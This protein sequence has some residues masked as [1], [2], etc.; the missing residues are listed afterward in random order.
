[1]REDGTP[2]LGKEGKPVKVTKYVPTEIVSYDKEHK[3]YIIT[4]PDSPAELTE[5]DIPEAE[6][7]EVEP[8]TID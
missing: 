2:V 3:Q 4:T 7:S 6:I 1:M 5:E 8:S